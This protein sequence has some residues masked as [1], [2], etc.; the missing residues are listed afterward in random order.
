[1]FVFE[2]FFARQVMFW[3]VGLP[4]LFAYVLVPTFAIFSLL[5]FCRYLL[6]FFWLSIWDD[7]ILSCFEKLFWKPDL[8][9]SSLCF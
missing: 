8:T 2:I 5:A 1:M 6:C 4:G 7:W 9:L 3:V